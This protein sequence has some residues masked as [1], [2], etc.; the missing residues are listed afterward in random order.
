[1]YISNSP[2][3][4]RLSSN[5]HLSHGYTTTTVMCKQVHTMRPMDHE[6]FFFCYGS[7]FLWL[8]F[9]PSQRR[10][11]DAFNTLH[12]RGAPSANTLFH[13]TPKPHHPQRKQN[14][15]IFPSFCHPSNFRFLCA[16]PL[17]VCFAHLYDRLATRM[18]FNRF[19]NFVI[20]MCFCFWMISLSTIACAG[21]LPL[22][23]DD[24]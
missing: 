10:S 22:M 11:Q 13:L 14:K 4:T 20:L 12:Q 1:M 6:H 17:C 8:N 3:R 15:L 5:G 19:S 18:P 16:M 23:C 2:C 24:F 9:Y 7:Q 21:L